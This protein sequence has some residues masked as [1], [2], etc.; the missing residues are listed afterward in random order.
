[1]T[2]VSSKWSE[3]HFLLID[4]H[5]LYIIKDNITIFLDRFLHCQFFY[6][7][8]DTLPSSK[9]SFL[10]IIWIIVFLEK[11]VLKTQNKW[12]L[13]KSNSKT[14]FFFKRYINQNFHLCNN[15]AFCLCNLFWCILLH[16]F[17]HICDIFLI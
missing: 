8:T 1:M 3:L 10:F 14:E 13:S 7:I 17:W 15:F 6:F 16:I 2:E 5:Y 4:L 11:E 9:L 12:K